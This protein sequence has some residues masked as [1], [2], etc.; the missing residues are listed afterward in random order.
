MNMKLFCLLKRR[1]HKTCNLRTCTLLNNIYKYYS[2]NYIWI[3]IFD[4]NTAK[5]LMYNITS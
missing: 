1:F 5:R 3:E 2:S 4:K